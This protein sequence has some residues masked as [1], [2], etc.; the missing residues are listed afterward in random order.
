MYQLNSLEHPATV[1][2]HQLIDFSSHDFRQ[3]RA[4]VMLVHVLVAAVVTD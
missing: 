4:G 3:I 1:S 2:P